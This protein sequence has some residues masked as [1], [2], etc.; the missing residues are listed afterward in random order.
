MTFLSISSIDSGRNVTNDRTTAQIASYTS[1]IMSLGSV[2]L[3]RLLVRQAQSL[4]TASETVR[5]SFPLIFPLLNPLLFVGNV[6]TQYDTHNARSR[7]TRNSV[8]SAICIVDMVVRCIKSSI[9][10]VRSFISCATGRF[11]FLPV[12][13]TRVSFRPTQLHAF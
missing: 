5:I 4:Q 7:D 9:T 10:A 2:L 3:S 13:C 8:C 11:L 6:F 1:V 12:S